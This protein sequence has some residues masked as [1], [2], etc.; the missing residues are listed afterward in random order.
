MNHDDK[1]LDDLDFTREGLVVL[2][3]IIASAGLFAAL[4]VATSVR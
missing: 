1:L 3:W 4:M 2:R